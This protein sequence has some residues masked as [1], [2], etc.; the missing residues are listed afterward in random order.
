MITLG[1]DLPEAF[2]YMYYLE[3]A[4]RVQVLAQ[5]TG[6]PLRELGPE[7]CQAVASQM[8][9]AFPQ[10]AHAYFDYAVRVLRETE[11]EFAS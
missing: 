5:A 1:V 8:K 4:A 3:Q 10:S 7:L 9:T 6:Q 11:P 2:G